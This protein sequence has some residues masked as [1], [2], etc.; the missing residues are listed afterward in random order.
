[1]FDFVVKGFSKARV[2]VSEEARKTRMM[3]IVD[4]DPFAQIDREKITSE[5]KIEEE[6][7][8]YILER[9]CPTD[10]TQ[11]EFVKYMPERQCRILLE[12]TRDTNNKRLNQLKDYLNFL[13]SDLNGLQDDFN[14]VDSKCKK[15]ED[16]ASKLKF[17]F[18][19]I[20]Y[21]K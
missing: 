4:I 7:E 3:G 20:V 14:V 10:I 16:R 6:K 8:V 2:Q 12:K 5:I 21:L 18:E 13:R 19:V 17:N 1:M 11:A 9:D 15:I